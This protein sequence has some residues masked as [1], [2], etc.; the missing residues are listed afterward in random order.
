MN[1]GREGYTHPPY[2]IMEKFMIK[3]FIPNTNIS[4]ESKNVILNREKFRSKMSMA[5]ISN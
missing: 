4:A 3:K 1:E 2:L 5:M